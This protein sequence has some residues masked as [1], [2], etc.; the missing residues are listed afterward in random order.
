MASNSEHLPFSDQHSA[1]GSLL[2]ADNSAVHIGG[3]LFDRFPGSGFRKGHGISDFGGDR[4]IQL[5]PILIVQQFG[6]AQ[7]LLKGGDWVAL[8]PLVHFILGAIELG[9][10]SG[11]DA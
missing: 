6:G 8:F 9:V 3:E 4:S 1:A 2:I 10:S 5:F 7:G 11:S